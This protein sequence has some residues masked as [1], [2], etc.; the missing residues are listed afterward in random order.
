MPANNAIDQRGMG[1]MGLPGV[2]DVDAVAERS[3]TP[4]NPISTL[5][6]FQGPSMPVDTVVNLGQHPQQTSGATVVVITDQNN[7]SNSNGDD[8]SS[9]GNGPDLAPPLGEELVPHSPRNA[10]KSSTVS[11]I[12]L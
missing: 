7:G 10:R 6:P 4:G 5:V 1:V 8:T 2:I 9:H 11:G 12:L 3:R